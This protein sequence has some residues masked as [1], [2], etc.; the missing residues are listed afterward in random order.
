M[1][2]RNSYDNPLTITY[3]YALH[4]FGAGSA[5]NFLVGPS[6]MR[7]RV[8]EICVNVTETF[9]AD[10][11]AGF[12]RVGTAADNDLYAELSMGTQA[13]DTALAATTQSGALKAVQITGDQQVEVNFV[14]PTGGTPAGIGDVYIT[15]DWH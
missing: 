12:V 4:D 15:I 13:A 6:G 11:T 14:A 10:T 1:T 5:E 3:T 8:R 9:T 2:D 7:G